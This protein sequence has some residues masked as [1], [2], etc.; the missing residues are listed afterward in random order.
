MK[1]R[2]I[3][4]QLVPAYLILIILSISIVSLYALQIMEKFYLHQTQS[5]LETQARLLEKQVLRLL[6]P[7][8]SIAIDLLCK[9]AAHGH[10]TRLTVIRT[11]GEVVGDSE[12]EPQNMKDH[13]NRSEIAEAYHGKTS[14]SVRFSGTLN[15]RM[16]FVA[17]PLTLNGQVTAILQ[18][19]LS[20]T[21][22]DEQLSAI[23]LNIFAIGFIIA[24]L[25]S[26]VCFYLSH[27]F[28]QPIKEMKNGAERFSKGDLDHRLAEPA[29]TELAG[30]ANAM[31]LMASQLK[32]RMDTVLNQRNELES[33]LGSMIEGVI[34]LDLEDNILRMNQAVADFFDINPDLFKG[35]SIQEVIRNQRL[36]ELIHK[37]TTSQRTTVDDIHIYKNNG[38]IFNTCCVPLRNAQ[39]KAVG[40]LVVLNDVTRLRHLE[41]MRR[42][43]AANVSHEIKTPLTAIKGFVET[44]LNDSKEGGQTHKFLT[45]VTRHVNRLTAIIDDLMYLSRIEKAN[46]IFSHKLER[47]KI[48]AVLNTALLL[49]KEKAK[50]K[51]IKIQ[52][53][54]NA[55][56]LIDATLIEQAA[57]NLLDNAIKYSPNN[58]KITITTESNH[59][60]IQIQIKDQGIGIAAKHL[61]RLFERFY[62]VDKA[63]SRKE[64]GTGLGLAIVKHI[65]SAHGGRVSVISRKGHGSTFTLHLPKKE[66]DQNKETIL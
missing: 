34:A 16:M 57:V 37:C 7:L 18:T 47:R 56:A 59:N 4:W 10:E 66:T 53:F 62:R 13:R 3:F 48:D 49:C 25:A 58:S 27:R 20:V 29:T 14:S 39:S 51:N 63:R 40:T 35:K 21:A 50:E 15:Q 45:I 33:V 8:D 30:L 24:L 19:S 54:G 28:S 43:F 42:D 17:I 46:E 38:K 55:K 60:E 23:S 5:N 1:R 44:L 22:M 65:A 26:A 41:I 31:N 61:P 6:D 12:E 64:G 52:I 2:R 32:T 11:D 9:E 36:P